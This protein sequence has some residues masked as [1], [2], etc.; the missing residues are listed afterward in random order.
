MR[1]WTGYEWTAA[2]RTMASPN[3][4]Q[5]EATARERSSGRKQALLGALILV[6]AAFLT[7]VWSQT[8][9]PGGTYFV[10][11]G[12]TAAGAIMIIRGLSRMDSSRD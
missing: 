4:L 6:G 2:R 10:F 7:F 12:A 8:V 1:W 11:W 3:Q 9:Q 5:Q